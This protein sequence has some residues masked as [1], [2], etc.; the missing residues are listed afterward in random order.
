MLAGVRLF[1]ELGT[2]TLV[3]SES[4]RPTLLHIIVVGLCSKHTKLKTV[5]TENN[6]FSYFYLTENQ[7]I[8]MQQV[9]RYSSGIVCSISGSDRIF[10]KIAIRYILNMFG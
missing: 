6:T 9:F 8:A 3:V 10:L 1:K 7:K 2:Y 5:N 4:C